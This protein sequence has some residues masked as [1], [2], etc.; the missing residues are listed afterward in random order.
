M[1]K[2]VYCIG[3]IHGN[4]L[5]LKQCFERSSFDYEKDQLIVLGDVCDG[6]PDVKKCIDELMKI[7]DLIYTIG[8]HD[9]WTLDWMKYGIIEERWIGQGG[10]RTI[11]SFGFIDKGSEEEQITLK[12]YKGNIER[13]FS[14]I[15]CNKPEGLEKYIE[16]FE[17]AYLYY[18]DDKNNLY[19]HGGLDINQ[20]D[21]KKQ[22]KDTL[23]WDRDMIETCWK[24]E[25]MSNND[26]KV[27]NYNQ[28]FIGHTT[29][30]LFKRACEPIIEPIF[31]C[32]VIDCDCGAGW[33]GKLCI[34][35]IDTQ[36][37]WLSDLAHDLYGSHQGR[38]R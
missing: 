21:I 26:Y 30:Q 5:A 29:T 31:A 12:T 15:N 14:Q 1:N 35:D 19:V 2:K 20:K 13:H 33:S 23:L 34:M 38:K 6:Y 17:K 16:F 32:N 22:S 8:N 28:I 7:K 10:V 9:I 37:Y 11:E 3:D 36:Q 24:K 25:R 4:Y 27:H 18:I